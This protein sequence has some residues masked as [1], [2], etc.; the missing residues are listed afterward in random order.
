MPD[1]RTERQSV[2]KQLDNGRVAHRYEW[3]VLAATL[4]VIP[5]LVIETDVKTGGWATFAYVA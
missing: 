3:I 2:W 1:D 4:A 5:V